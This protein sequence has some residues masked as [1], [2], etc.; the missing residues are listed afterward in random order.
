VYE[1][2]SKWTKKRKAKRREEKRDDQGGSFEF[3]YK[4]KTEEF[5][6]NRK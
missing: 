4:G 6:L 1:I 2:K 5:L 3:F